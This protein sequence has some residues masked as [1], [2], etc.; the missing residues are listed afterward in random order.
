MI[1]LVIII[2]ITIILRD[3]NTATQQVFSKAH[4]VSLLVIQFIST[5]FPTLIVLPAAAAQQELLGTLSVRETLVYSALLRLPRDWDYARKMKRVDDTIF[6]L[7]LTDAQNTKIG[8][9]LI[10]G[11]S[12]DGGQHAAHRHSDVAARLPH[13]DYAPHPDALTFWALRACVMNQ[14]ALT[15]AVHVCS[16]FS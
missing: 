11:I 5:V 14:P 7:G 4:G 15:A 10:K 6:E 13:T 16:C 1:L 12:G 8:N 3:C 2:T 9:V